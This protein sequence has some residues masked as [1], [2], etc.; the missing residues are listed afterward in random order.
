MPRALILCEEEFQNRRRRF[1]E[2]SAP[3]PL[4]YG[5]NALER[6][7]YRLHGQARTQR[8]VL[9]K[10]RDVVEH[11]RGYPVEQ[12]LRAIPS[13]ASA[14]LVIALLEH[15]GVLAGLWKARG[16][17]PYASRPLVI[18]SCWLADDV[19]RAGAQQRAQLRSRFAHADLITHMSRHE[20][21][22]LVDLGL[23]QSQL[24]TQT[25]RWRN[26]PRMRHRWRAR[27]SR[28]RP[29]SSS[30]MPIKKAMAKKP[31]ERGILAR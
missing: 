9:S 3:S 17:P 1:D 28:N 25:T 8:H 6:H 21:E 22:I 19:R 7:G 20:T 4:P 27:R 30:G 26:S 23:D 18:W 11:R 12:A 31:R 13:A 2:G 29:S 15:Q 16:L 10:L 14:D 5:I 24:A